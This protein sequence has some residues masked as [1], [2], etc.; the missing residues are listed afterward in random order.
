[1]PLFLLDSDFEY[2]SLQNELEEVKEQERV[3]QASIKV[4]PLTF[5]YLTGLQRA[6]ARLKKLQ[7]KA[8]RKQERLSAIL[9]LQEKKKQEAR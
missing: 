8:E 1:M 5:C 7:A 6:Q 4:S 3:V 2:T 9:A